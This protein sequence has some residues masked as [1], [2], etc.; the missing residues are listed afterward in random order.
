MKTK[1]I[2]FLGLFLLFL[3]PLTV[4]AGVVINEVTWMGTTDSANDEWVELYNNSSESVDLTDW[5]L[6]ATDGQPLI[7]LSGVISANGYFLLERTDDNSVPGITADQIYTGGLGNSGE[8][9][10]LKDKNNTVIDDF[11]FSNGWPAGDNTTKQTMEKLA[12]GW[13]TSLNPG[14]TP[15]TQNS[16]GTIEEP[17]LTTEET[18]TTT[19]ETEATIEESSAP[20]IPVENQPPI[21]NA[22]D[23]IIAFIDEEIAFDGS[24]SHDS[25]GNDL[26]YEWNLGEGE[27][28]NEIIVTHKYSYPG[29]YLVTL[30]VFDNRYYSSDTITVEIYPKKITINEFLPSPEGKDE[31]EEWIELYNDSDQIINISGWQLDD[32]EEG[33]RPFVFPKNTLI[34]PKNYLVF[35][36][37]TT[38]IAL[39]NDKGKVRLLLS[40]GTVFQEIS[41]EKAP[42]GKSSARTPEGFV[43]S[44]PTPGLPN[45]IGA[46]NKELSHNQPLQT[47]TTGYPSENLALNY[48]NDENQIQ[49]GWAYLPQQA[50]SEKFSGNLLANLEQSSEKTDYKLILFTTAIILVG[51]TIGIVIVKKKKL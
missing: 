46:N 15:R 50:S 28:K 24:K 49:G 48:K 8:H 47:K 33:S 22:G 40:T 2:L 43:W 12:A 35:S 44:M 6:E 27:V 10:Q 25:D 19:E 21:A 3:M 30:M 36:R 32:E 4:K 45:I 38:D 17:E 13:Q 29:T 51:L 39:N 11:D 16:S 42:E 9:L 31:E 34:A 5:I 7:N 18:E 20:A 1:Y 14:G 37:P 41:Y 26:T 23:N